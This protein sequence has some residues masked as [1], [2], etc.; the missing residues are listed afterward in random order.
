M[1]DKMSGGK[2]DRGWAWIIVIGV[3]IIN[4]SFPS[5]FSVFQSLIQAIGIDI[6]CSELTY[7]IH[8]Y[9]LTMRHIP[10]ACAFV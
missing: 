2:A 10:H 9:V 3:T 4:V 1:I 6:A 7:K 8:T 5:E